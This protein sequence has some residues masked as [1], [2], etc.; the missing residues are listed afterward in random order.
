MEIHVK[1]LI[2]KIW[3][4]GV[5]ESEIKAA[6]IIKEAEIKADT[7]IANAKKD[8]ARITAKAREEALRSEQAGRETLKQAGRDLILNLQSAITDLFNTLVKKDVASAMNDKIM[9]EAIV[10]MMSSWKGDVANIQVVLA[11]KDYRDLEM[12]LR[13]KLAQEINKGLEIRPSSSLD[14]GFLVAVKDGS[15]YHNFSAEGIAAVLSESLNPKISALLNEG[16]KG[17]TE[18]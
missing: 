2:E 17:K 8:A 11:E 10:R 1:E 18:A 4:D 15:A 5:Q 13:E 3:K 16:L 7:I 9:G 6:D 12:H 14:S